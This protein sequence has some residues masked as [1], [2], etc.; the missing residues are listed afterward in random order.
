MIS[1]SKKA[2]RSISRPAVSFPATLSRACQGP[3]ILLL[4]YFLHFACIQT[5]PVANQ[6]QGKK[7][8]KL[9]FQEIKA[10]SVFPPNLLHY[11]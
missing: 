8:V 2:P 3:F 9:P 11:R 5:L 1:I 10:I 7:F 6:M 4:Q